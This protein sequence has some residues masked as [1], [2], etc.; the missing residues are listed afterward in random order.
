MKPILPECCVLFALLFLSKQAFAQT[1]LDRV[2]WIPGKIT[3]KS[4]STTAEISFDASTREGALLVKKGM[5]VQAINPD[6]ID[7]FEFVNPL[8]DQHDTIVFESVMTQFGDKKKQS[9]SFLRL[10]QKGKHFSIYTS[11]MPSKKG[12]GFAMPL[13]GN[14]M[15]FGFGSYIESAKV[16]FL[17][18]D[19]IAYQISHPS[20]LGE[21][22][23]DTP[24][25]I[26][27]HEFFSVIGSRKE[28]VEYFMKKE[29]LKLYRPEDFSRI[30][31]YLNS[32]Y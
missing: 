12:F 27:K 32:I 1:N 14:L 7:S 2:P 28:R 6:Q 3:L 31:E 23:A 11:Y 19:G 24:P 15:V 4:Q 18:I 9:M 25:K 30:V 21:L 13:P 22:D 17:S 26:E 5:K 29:K 8:E 20:Q 10:L 16:L